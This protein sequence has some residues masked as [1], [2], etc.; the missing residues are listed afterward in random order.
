MQEVRPHL[1]LTAAG[2]GDGCDAPHRPLLLLRLAFLFA[3]ARSRSRR[4]GRPMIILP[5]LFAPPDPAAPITSSSHWSCLLLLLQPASSLLLSLPPASLRPLARIAQDGRG[6]SAG[7]YSTRMVVDR[8]FCLRVPT[9]LPL[10]GVA[11][12][13][14]AGITVW[15]PMKA[16]ENAL[17]CSE[18]LIII[19]VV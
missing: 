9:N 17:G 15:T 13:L 12:L 6:V 3:S 1:Q 2:A 11:P 4:V 10:E 18:T 8:Q 16:C 19:R 5:R 7:G 14:C